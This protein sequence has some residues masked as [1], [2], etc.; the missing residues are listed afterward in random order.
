VRG[1]VWM[2]LEWVDGCT[3]ELT[4]LGVRCG[5]RLMYM[6]VMRVNHEVIYTLC[7]NQ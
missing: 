6:I 4:S 7:K 3:D 2:L 5:W 1:D